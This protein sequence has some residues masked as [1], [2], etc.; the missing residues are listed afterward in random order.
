[1]NAR[2]WKCGFF[3]VACGLVCVSGLAIYMARIADLAVERSG[4]WQKESQSR[5]LDAEECRAECDLLA[6]RVDELTKERDLLKL[7]LKRAAEALGLEINSEAVELTVFRDKLLEVEKRLER[8]KIDR[9]NLANEL[10]EE[11]RDRDQ[12]AE[13]FSGR[14]LQLERERAIN[15][16]LKTDLERCRAELARRPNCCQCHQPRADHHRHDKRPD[17]HERKKR[18]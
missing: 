11:K 5:R 15:E 16:A 13:E 4:K 12:L 10:A 2:D 14:L 8:A 17:K 18:K 7:D 1:M 6:A 3:V 9:D